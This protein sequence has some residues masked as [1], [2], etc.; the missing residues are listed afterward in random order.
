MLIGQALRFCRKSSAKTCHLIQFVIATR[1]AN[2]GRKWNL[3]SRTGQNGSLVLSS[4]QVQE[5]APL[6][7]CICIITLVIRTIG[8]ERGRAARGGPLAG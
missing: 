8:A 1:D 6:Q 7:H 2:A 3:P 4:I 5:S